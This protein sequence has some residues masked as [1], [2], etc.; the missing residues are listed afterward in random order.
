VLGRETTGSTNKQTNRQERFGNRPEGNR[1]A[2]DPGSMFVNRASERK[3][4]HLKKPGKSIQNEMTREKRT[5]TRGNKLTKAG[6][7]FRPVSS[8]KL[9]KRVVSARKDVLYQEGISEF[10][11]PFVS[12]KISI[13]PPEFSQS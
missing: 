13:L 7:D 4:D 12:L 1:R 6:C 10:V 9:S 5:G 3:V 2:K 11:S 8:I